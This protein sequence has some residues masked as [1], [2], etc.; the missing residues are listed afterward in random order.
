MR[1]NDFDYAKG[2]AMVLII[3]GH[4]IGMSEFELKL[5]Y[6]FHVP[7]FFVISGM[8][9]Y[10]TNT[11]EKTWVH[12]IKSWAEHMLIPVIFWEMVLSLFYCFAKKISVL[13][14]FKNSITLNFNLSVLWFIPCLLLAEIIWIIIIKAW[15][16]EMSIYAICIIIICSAVVAELV[17]N[18]F[19]RRVLIATVFV[20]FGYGIEQSRVRKKSAYNYSISIMTNITLVIIWSATTL[21]NLRVDLSAGVLGNIFLYYIHSLAGCLIVIII[22]E[23]LPERLPVVGW[24]GRHTMGFLVTHVFIR[25]AIV[26]IEEALLGYYLDGWC[27]AIPMLFIDIIVVW[28]IDYFVPEIIGQKR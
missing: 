2:I 5:I 17:T 27:L 14:L 1:R 10:Y 15:K 3:I 6:S 23:W 13:Q 25:H 20:I 7:L 9:L 16:K 21:L 19:F 22:C 28:A 24:I 11:V 26:R 8:L 4:A 18:L 12:I